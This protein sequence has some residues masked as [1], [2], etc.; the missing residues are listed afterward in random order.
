MTSLIYINQNRMPEF[1]VAT[2]LEEAW[3]LGAKEGKPFIESKFRLY[4]YDGRN[5]TLK[6]P[7]LG[8]YLFYLLNM[9]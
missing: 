1:V 3:I 5:R 4:E 6:Y 8:S 7:D 2:N 9:Q